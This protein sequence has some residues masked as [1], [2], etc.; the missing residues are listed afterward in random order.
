MKLACRYIAMMMHTAWLAAASLA[1]VV[2]CFDRAI[3][4]IHKHIVVFSA[5]QKLLL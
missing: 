2:L 3:L 5:A 1:V 4:L